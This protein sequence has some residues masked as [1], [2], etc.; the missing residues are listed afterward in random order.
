M[1]KY[2]NIGLVIVVIATISGVRH[3]YSIK[4]DSRISFENTQREIESLRR[5]RSAIKARMDTLG[6]R[7]LN[8][9]KSRLEKQQEQLKEELDRI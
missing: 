6:I 4:L 1:N 9:E 5:E 3:Y 2:V 7:Q 8:S